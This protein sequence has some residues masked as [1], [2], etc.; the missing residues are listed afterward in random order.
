MNEDRLQTT[1]N[2]SKTTNVGLIDLAKH[3]G[4]SKNVLIESLCIIECLNNISISFS[5]E[6][7]D[8]LWDKYLTKNESK[9]TNEFKSLHKRLPRHV[10]NEII[11]FFYELNKIPNI[12]FSAK[13]Q[14]NFYKLND[15]YLFYYGILNMKGF[16]MEDY[17]NKLSINIK[18]YGKENCN[19]EEYIY[20]GKMQQFKHATKVS[21]YFNY[22]CLKLKVDN[23]DCVR[24]H[25]ESLMDLLEVLR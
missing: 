11:K 18:T 14:A 19:H 13:K 8:N 1:V 15:E 4:I 21:E 10:K 24:I 6:Q 16:P 25:Y 20:I 2:F 3:L 22:I 12:K 9:L 5:N 17:L 7:L 23:C